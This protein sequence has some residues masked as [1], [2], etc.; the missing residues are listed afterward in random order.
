MHAYYRWKHGRAASAFGNLGSGEMHMM[1]VPQSVGFTI[2][3]GICAKDLFLFLSSAWSVGFPISLGIEPVFGRSCFCRTLIPALRN[4]AVQATVPDDP[5]VDG[6]AEMSLRAQVPISFVMGRLNEPV[7]SG[8]HAL[9]RLNRRM[10][11]LGG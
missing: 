11:N 8:T 4:F 3:L 6:E 7:S 2:S 9:F 5:C 1:S 10:F